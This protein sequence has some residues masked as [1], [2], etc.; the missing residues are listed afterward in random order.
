MG[1]TLG[2]EHNKLGTMPRVFWMGC[3]EAWRMMCGVLCFHERLLRLVSAKLMG[4]D[5]CMVGLVMFVYRLLTRVVLL[6]GT[7]DYGL[8]CDG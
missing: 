3:V 2:L 5:G 4:V 8:V 6:R 1:E 7:I